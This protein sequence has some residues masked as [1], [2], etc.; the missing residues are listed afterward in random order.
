M[1]YTQ[2]FEAEWIPWTLDE[3]LGCCDCGLVHRIKMRRVGNRLQAKFFRDE[4]RTTAKRRRI[5]YYE[6]KVGNTTLSKPLPRR[7]RV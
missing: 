5:N 1:K 3:I 7:A 4:R 2:I 6:N